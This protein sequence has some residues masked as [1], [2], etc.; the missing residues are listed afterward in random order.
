MKI[1]ISG[2]F[3]GLPY[4]EAYD[5]FA[6]AESDLKQT[7]HTPV[8]PLK[9]ISE[10]ASWKTSMRYAI[11]LMMDCDGIFLL[12]SWKDSEGA[13]IEFE[14]AMKLG[15]TIYF[16]RDLNHLLQLKTETINY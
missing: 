6:K 7:G 10:Q 9:A 8:N 2:K 13:R 16:E 1:Y 15:F 5:A 11:S 12:D 3:S 4:R 14:L